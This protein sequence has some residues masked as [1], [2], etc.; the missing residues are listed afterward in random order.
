MLFRPSLLALPFT[1]RMTLGRCTFGHAWTRYE[2]NTVVPCVGQARPDLVL[3]RPVTLW[4]VNRR[5]RRHEFR[6][7]WQPT[8]RV[9]SCSRDFDRALRAEGAAGHGRSPG[10]DPDGAGERRLGARFQL[11]AAF[12]QAVL[13]LAVAQQPDGQARHH[14][15]S[16]RVQGQGH[17]RGDD[18]P[19]ERR[20]Y[21]ART[22]L[23]LVGVARPL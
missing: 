5:K 23:S 3:I 8:G 17:G 16:G 2:V 11:A 22:G 14:P 18:L 21:A 6:V 7:R 4:F 13:L 10:A 12:G 20:Q 15:R 1:V 9:C 19:G